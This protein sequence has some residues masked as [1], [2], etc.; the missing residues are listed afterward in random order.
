[1]NNGNIVVNNGNI[2]VNNGNIVRKF[3]KELRGIFPEPRI[4]VE[5]TKD[6]DSCPSKIGGKTQ[7]TAARD[8]FTK[9]SPKDGNVANKDK[10]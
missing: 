8:A 9:D 6:A 3:E 1:M 7:K 2:V 5:A 10:D 4:V